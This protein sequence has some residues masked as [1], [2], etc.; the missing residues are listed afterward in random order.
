MV[1]GPVELVD[2]L[3]TESI[4]NFRPREANPDY[5]Q[6]LVTVIAD[7]CQ[8]LKASNLSPESRVKRGSWLN[9]HASRLIKWR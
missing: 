8:I 3:R 9:F 1:Q 4:S 7:V 2:R 6:G 5:A